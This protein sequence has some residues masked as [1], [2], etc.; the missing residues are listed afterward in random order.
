MPVRI[1]PP[2]KIPVTVYS[3]VTPLAYEALYIL[4]KTTML[5]MQTVYS[6]L[7]IVDGALY[8]KEVV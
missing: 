2:V 5:D 8:F 1:T 6:D 7:V 4:Y 3:T